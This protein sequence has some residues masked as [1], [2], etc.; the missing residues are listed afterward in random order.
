LLYTADIE[1]LVEVESLRQYD[2]VE[3]SKSVTGKTIGTYSLSFKKSSDLANAGV[4]GLPMPSS[5]NDIRTH[6]NP[7]GTTYLNPGNWRR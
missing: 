5:T 6:G 1:E 7:K 4:H 2:V 3:H